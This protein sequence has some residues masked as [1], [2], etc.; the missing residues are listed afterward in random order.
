MYSKEKFFGYCEL[1]L[2][3]NKKVLSTFVCTIVNVLQYVHPRIRNYTSLL[4]FVCTTIL[5]FN[6]YFLNIF[7]SSL[8]IKDFVNLLFHSYRKNKKT[9]ACLRIFE[10]NKNNYECGIC[11]GTKLIFNKTNYTLS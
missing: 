1:A 2:F 10:Q 9:C 8:I 4:L 3:K 11:S 7:L 6:Y 5:Y